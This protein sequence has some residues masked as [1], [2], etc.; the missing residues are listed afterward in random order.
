MKKI[1]L[2]LAC[3]AMSI[4][5]ISAKPY[6][7]KD[8]NALDISSIY[9][10][11]VVRSNTFSVDVEAS[12]D[13]EKYLDVRT[14]GSVLV[15]DVNNHMT[16]KAKKDSYIR[17]RISM[18]ELYSVELSG[19]SKLT[20]EDKFTTKG[21]FSL[22]VSGASIVNKLIIDADKIDVDQSGVSKVLDLKMNANTLEMEVSGTGQHNASGRVEKAILDISGAAKVAFDVKTE[23]VSSELSGASRVTMEACELVD[24]YADLGGTSVLDL[25]AGNLDE[26]VVEASGASCLNAQTAVARNVK[27]ECS[28]ASKANV[29]VTENLNVV[30]SG[31]SHV[32]YIEEGKLRLNNINTSGAS[33]AVKVK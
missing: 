11:T 13:M 23:S 29:A 18:P 4:T 24:L 1:L 14:R 8:F 28:G 5:A 3:I 12:G 19:L 26:L 10:V 27:V 32:T 7:L 25:N 31:A 15:L 17:A 6:S 22:D 33:T 9:E 20:C 21:R 30:A 2:C 16:L